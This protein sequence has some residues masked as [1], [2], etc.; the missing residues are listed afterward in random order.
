M[1]YKKL[2]KRKEKI[3]T[4]ETVG[5]KKELSILDMEFPT[6]RFTPAYGNLKEQEKLVFQRTCKNLSTNGMNVALDSALGGMNGAFRFQDL[7]TQIINPLVFDWFVS[8]GFI[9]HQVCGMLAQ[10]WL[11]SKACSMPAEDATRKGFEVTNNNGEEIE[12][13]F[14]DDIKRYDVSY[15]LNKKLVEFVTKGRIFGIR[16]A[17]FKVESSDPKYYEQ[18]FNIDGVTPG[19]YKGIVQVDPYWIMPELDAEA[20]SN[21]ASLDFYE[22]TWWVISGK[23]YHKSHLVIM[24]GDEVVDVLKPTYLYGGIPVP[25]KILN[26]VY[27]SERAADEAPAL[28]LT[29]RAVVANFDLSAAEAN[30]QS[31]RSKLEKFANFRNNF[32]IFAVG[33]NDTVQQFDTSLADFDSL[34]MSQYQLV[35]SAADVPSTRLF[36]TQPKGFNATGESEEANYHEMLESIQT[37]DLTPFVERHHLLLIKS[38][39]APKYGIE[40]FA[41]TIKWNPLDAMTA[42]ENAEVQ[43]IKSR[44]GSNLVNSGAIMPE[45]E[46]KRVINDRDSG[47]NGLSEELPENEQ[48]TEE[49]E[50]EELLANANLTGEE[51]ND[52]SI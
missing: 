5:T 19:S 28:A 34:I 18:P 32:A 25:Q 11:I 24:R 37:H 43:E 52:N 21:P 12:A 20:A 45:E 3:V 22:P 23:R 44:T 30:P 13:K 6:L 2:F 41:T 7:S 48:M 8:Q 35:A 36:G 33:K 17:L 14:L 29:K 10:H 26:R 27:C 31:F 16:I 50:N 42:K 51:D 46:R 15:K 39:I 49:L 4:Q 40:P 9:T 38:E 1:F 47:Y